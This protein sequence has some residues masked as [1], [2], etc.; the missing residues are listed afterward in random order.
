MSLWPDY[1]SELFVDRPQAMEKIR[2]WVDDP[3]AKRVL[4]LVAPPGSGKSWLLRKIEEEWKPNRLTVWLDAPRLI[5]RQEEQ[6][7]DRMLNHVAF[8]EWFKEVQ[9]SASRFCVDLKPIGDS[10]ALDAQIEALIDMVCCCAVRYDPLL[11]VDAYDEITELQ[12]L[13]L[14]LR[15]LAKFISRPCTR[16]LIAVR[17]ESLVRE[18]TIRRH[19]ELFP[20]MQDALN[21]DFARQQFEKWFVCTQKL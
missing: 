4:V 19:Q 5:H 21:K 7:P 13:I 14:S 10:V 20:L 2:H 16:M 15:V 9:Q 8:E 6:N 3:Y 11:I 17:S 12:A 1:R 18:D